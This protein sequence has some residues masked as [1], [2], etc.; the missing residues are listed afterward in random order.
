[1]SIQRASPSE[2]IADALRAEIEDGTLGLGQPLPSD[3]ELAARFGVSTPTAAKARAMLVA[4]GLVAS[5]SGAASTVRA[6]RSPPIAPGTHMRRARR[7]GR[8]YPEGHYVRILRAG[9]VPAAPEIAAI[10]EAEPDASVIERVRT[11]YAADD[12]PLAVSTTYVSAALLDQ[13]PAL[14][15]VRRIKQGT[16]LYIEQQTGRTAAAIEASVVCGPGGTGPGSDVAKLK[17]SPYS[18]VLTLSTTTYDAQGV[19]LAHEIELHPS[20]TPIALDLISL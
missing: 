11:T 9:V 4:L 3:A 14:V 1:M 2:Q 6:Q 5:R 13:C 20:A 16:T 8:I 19:V 15:T 12:K 17:L 7:T 18:C 10:L